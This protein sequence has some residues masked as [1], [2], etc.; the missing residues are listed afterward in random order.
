MKQTASRMYRVFLYW[1]LSTAV[2]LAAGA[3]TPLYAQDEAQSVIAALQQ[4]A[5]ENAT[6]SLHPATGRV[7]FVHF[8]PGTMQAANADVASAADSFL[9]Q[10][11]AVFGLRDPANELTLHAQT[12]DQLGATHLIY[13]QHYQGVPVFGG[14][15]RLHFTKD[16]ALSAANGVI[17]PDLQLDVTPRLTPEAAADLTRRSVEATNPSHGAKGWQATVQQLWIWR[18]RLLEG[19]PGPNHLVYEVLVTRDESERT[20]LYIDAHT[21]ETVDQVSGVHPAIQ[22]QVYKNVSFLDPAS[23]VWQ[24][25]DPLPYTDADPS[26]QANINKIIDYT[27]DTYNFFA[28]L[29][30]GTFLSWNGLDGTMP[31]L[32]D[33][34]NSR[35]PNASW[36]GQ[37]VNYCVD[38]VSDDLVAHEWAHG[39]SQSSHGLV[40]MW[41]PGAL[42]EAYSD[43]WGESIDLLN[44]AGSD[45]PNVPRTDGACT[46]FTNANGTDNSRRWLVFEDARGFGQAL[47][48]LWNP[49]CF[50]DPGKVSDP[51]YACGST[52]DGGVHT[53]SGVPNH[54]FALLV[55]GGNYNG[56]QVRG[57][58]LTKAVNLYWRAQTVYQTRTSDFADHADALEQSCRDLV[59]EPLYQP[60]T[61]TPTATL[62]T[63]RITPDDCTQLRNAIAAVEL[64][65]EPERCR[66]PT[67]LAPTAPPFCQNEGAV[68]PL[69]TQDWEAG[70][71]EWRVS[72][73]DVVSPTTLAQ[74]IGRWS[75]RSLMAAR[76][77]PPLSKIHGAAMA[78]PI[79]NAVC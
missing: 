41:Q 19:Q 78:L 29:S 34:P 51:N 21:G 52:D 16:H 18:A 4:A 54:A 68:V 64:R 61:D 48:D 69:L 35:C 7:R 49:G 60:N 45:L 66:F 27:E 74:Q 73:R 3:I 31:N 44:N 75:A 42:N 43:I 11:G 55:D 58:G 12:T 20:L 15:L 47:R 63:E 65:S 62:A 8:A 59:G 56:Q 25:G 50:G 67:M 6:I 14:E 77:R 33:N 1:L 26:D 40:Y 10:Y 5:G 79:S 36:S 23:L 28:S 30:G 71:A 22:R 72:R 39:Y 32:Y 38:V 13:H 46:L 24:E 57:I 37:A 9:H 76:A 53:N 17:I 70:L 2:G